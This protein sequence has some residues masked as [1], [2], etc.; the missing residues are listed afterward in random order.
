MASF[1]VTFRDY[2]D[3]LSTVSFP[4]AEPAGDGSDYAAILAD[5]GDIIFALNALS[6]GSIIRYS[7]TVN[8]TETGDG[9][10]SNNYAQRESGLRLFWEEGVSPFAKGHLTVPMPD[11]LLVATAGTDEVD[12]AGVTVVNALVALLEA[13]M[14]SPAGNDIEFYRGVIVGR[15]N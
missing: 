14:Q 4:V 13:N 7:L 9:R 12:I 8:Y 5:M 10:P 11:L 1:N 6:I 3:E 15:R 2:S